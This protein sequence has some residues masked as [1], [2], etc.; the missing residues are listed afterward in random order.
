MALL[1]LALSASGCASAVEETGPASGPSLPGPLPSTVEPGTSSVR[2]AAY[3]L[4][5]VH[6]YSGF[7]HIGSL[8]YF[9]GVADTLTKQGHRVFVPQLDAF[10]TSEVRGAQLVAFLEQ[11]L[12]ESGAQKVN[13]ICHSQGGLDCRYAATKLDG[14]ISAIVTIGTG[15]RGSSIADVALGD[16]PGPLEDALAF[17]L[18]LFGDSI[19]GDSNV[20]AATAQLSTKGAEAFNLAYPDRP[21]VAYFS[22]AGRTHGARGDI[23]CATPAEP[24]FIARYD[25]FT[26]PVNPLFA[27]PV[28]IFDSESPRPTYDGMVTVP[29]ARWGT[30]LGCIPADHTDEICQIAGASPGDGNPFDCQGFYRHLAAWLVN[31]GF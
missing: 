31:W 27:V 15:H 4:V 10:N 25:Q 24:A 21:S 17:T 5:L 8:D 16:L 11:R 20:R 6:G 12:A 14:R 9:Y 2:H 22:I 29:S 30:F 26:D 3:P 19:S 1:P 18:D 28:L 13:L 7:N 23:D